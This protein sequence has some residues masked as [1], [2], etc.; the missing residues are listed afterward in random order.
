[1]EHGEQWSH[2]LSLLHFLLLYVYLLFVLQVDKG[3]DRIKLILTGNK[4][5]FTEVD[6]SLDENKHEKEYM[7]KNTKHT[8]KV[9]FPQVFNNGQYVGVRKNKREGGRREAVHVQ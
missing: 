6:I 2:Y 8:A 4:M 3:M 5:Q 9:M 7:Q 1:M